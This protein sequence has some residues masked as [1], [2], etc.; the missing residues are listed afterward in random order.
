MSTLLPW[1]YGH[2]LLGDATYIHKEEMGAWTDYQKPI[3]N[4]V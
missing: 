3:S 2:N 1:F 4:I